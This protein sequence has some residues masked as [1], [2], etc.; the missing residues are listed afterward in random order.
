MR[1]TL[2]GDGVKTG[3]GM[4]AGGEYRLTKTQDPY[5]GKTLGQYQVLERVGTGGMAIVYKAKHVQ[6]GTIVA[7]KMLKAELAMDADSVKR[8]GREAKALLNL[9]HP[10]LLKIHETGTTATGQPYYVA[11]FLQGK[12]LDEVIATSGPIP[13]DQAIKIFVQ[14][15]DAMESAHQ[16]GIIHRDL[17]PSNIMLEKA[18]DGTT[19]AK[20]VD[21]GIVMLT[22]KSQLLSQ[23]LTKKG[24]VWG[25]PVYMSPEQCLGE[26]LD[27]RTDVYALGAVIYEC[28][29]GQA[30]FSGKKIADIVIQQL[31]KMP[32]PFAAIRSELIDAQ[33]LEEVV[34]RALQ[35]NRD[36]RYQ[37]MHQFMQAL[38][39]LSP[40]LLKEHTSATVE[41]GAVAGAK[42]GDA[43]TAQTDPAAAQI[44]EALTEKIVA[45]A[46]SD[47]PPQPAPAAAATAAAGRPSPKP[48]PSD[49]FINTYLSQRFLVQSK[50]GEGGMCVVYKAK[51]ELVDRTVAIKVLKEDYCADENDIK[52]FQREAKALSKL[53]HQGLVTIHDVGVAPSGQPYYV[54]EYVEG[55]TIATIVD[56]GLIFEPARAVKLFIQ[57]CEA[58]DHA[59][60]LG[61][62]HRDLKPENIMIIGEGTD[63]EQA[64]IVD[65]GIVKFTQ[66]SQ[67]RSQR[68][69]ATGI[70]WGSAMYMSPE[71]CEG[72]ELDGRSDIYTLGLVMYEALTG[73]IAFTGKNE[74]IIIDKQLTE[75]PASFHTIRSDLGLPKDLEQVV[76]RCV[77]KDKR[78]R[79]Q[80]MLE[81]KDALKQTEAARG[82]KHRSSAVPHHAHPEP[83]AGSQLA[84]SQSA[85]SRPPSQSQSTSKFSVAHIILIL[86][87]AAVLGALAFGAKMLIG[88]KS[89]YKHPPSKQQPGAPSTAPVGTELPSATTD[90]PVTSKSTVKTEEPSGTKASP[91]TATKPGSRSATINKHTRHHSRSGKPA[92]LEADVIDPSQRPKYPQT[93]EDRWQEF[94]DKHRQMAD[95]Q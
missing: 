17:K 8:F 86:A 68:L 15:A 25:S 59:H 18:A 28:V 55:R 42:A 94:R 90:K 41:F 62:V 79:F 7:V 57:L 73:R 71:Q 30:V 56:S 78:K 40:E 1:R 95:P 84:G 10:G 83:A 58:M 19:C 23:K 69:T 91:A 46:K 72:Q 22:E 61:I 9:N 85:S 76:F 39:I 14:V 80:S 44:S 64:K 52:R 93:E 49:P 74:T 87:V 88:N 32:L 60:K 27:A 29:T 51:Q 92:P 81:L 67:L 53:T 63:K 77:A 35:K 24:E 36:K 21:F 11:D 26:E 38:I 43:K 37:S 5:A 33:D 50:I 12:S 89:P 6:T 65:F 3:P 48:A 54:M 82:A 31:N 66:D 16:R 20:V 34:F 4:I 45:A 13:K 47:P 70:V 2:A 75:M